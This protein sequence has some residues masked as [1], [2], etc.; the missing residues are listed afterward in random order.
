MNSRK[1]LAIAIALA[2]VVLWVRATLDQRIRVEP[3]PLRQTDN[4]IANPVRE[5][6]GLEHLNLI[7]VQSINPTA[8]DAG[9]ETDIETTFDCEPF[10][11]IMM[12]HCRILIELLKT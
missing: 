8:G 6:A 11:Q 12:D 9:Y 3:P 5:S 2:I 4:G 1:F 7:S 10:P